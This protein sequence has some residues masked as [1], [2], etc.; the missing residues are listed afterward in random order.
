MSIERAVKELYPNKAYIIKND[1][2][3][4]KD[5]TVPDE[6]ELAIKIREYQLR[7]EAFSYIENRQDAYPNILDQLDKIFHDGVDAWKAEIQAIKD[8]NPKFVETDETIAARRAQAEF[9][10]ALDKYTKAVARLNQY[11]VSEGREA[12]TEELDDDKVLII[13]PGV[14]P[15]PATISDW[16]TDSEGSVTEIQIPN[17]DIAKDEQ[18]RSDAQAV[19][20]ATPQE[21]KDYYEAN[22]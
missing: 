10:V 21:V 3:I 20:D 19:V 18:E 6:N 9:D 15:A 4:I 2:V 11:I 17:P 14:D 7:D 16:I 12:V 1:K 13:V 5:G 8:A 22:N